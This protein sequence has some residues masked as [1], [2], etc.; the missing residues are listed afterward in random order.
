MSEFHIGR[1][2]IYNRELEVF[3]Y[4]LMSHGNEDAPVTAAGADKTTS[5][6]IINAFMEI[7][8][9]NIV[10]KHT[11]FIKLAERFL[12]TDTQLPLPPGKV[13]LKI[14]GYIQ[15]NSTVIEAAARLTKAG[16]KLA[17]DDY[18]VHKHLQPLAIMASIIDINIESMDRPALTA[19]IKILKKLHPTLLV[20][21]VKTHAE[22]E[23][24]RDLGVDYFQGYFLSRPRIITGEALATNK[25]SVMNLLATLHNPDT[26]TEAIE[27]AISH[28][29]SLSYKIL[30]LINSAF[31]NAPK[32]IESIKHAVMML[33]RKQ[34]CTWASMMALTGMNDKPREQVRIAM[35]RAKSCELLAKKAK[36]KPLDAFF[37]VG[38]FSALDL[39]MDHSLEELIT[40]LPLADTLK[41]SLLN[42]EGEPG[43]ALNCTL[44][45]E[46]GD[47]VN[48]RFGNLTASELTAA[49]IEAMQWAEEV[50]NSI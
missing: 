19:H 37:T 1:Q 22:Y 16:F 5:Q 6:V 20:D 45:Q 30:K 11:A 41:K 48:I 31:F 23:Y 28:D 27:H 29:V 44:A 13:I 33:G 10:G 38:M 7:G 40:P 12:T 26:E 14:P 36:L 35:L 2:P 25:I 49:N 21:Y 50:L 8:I 43:A 4:E 15:V 18:L 46:T 32:K 34:L 47:W 17:L 42:R 24:C 9:D 39:L 3:A